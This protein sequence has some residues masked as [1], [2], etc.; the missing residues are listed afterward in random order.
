MLLTGQISWLL[1]ALFCSS[2]KSVQ[3]YPLKCTGVSKTLSTLLGIFLL[4]LLFL[5]IM[6]KEV[7]K[8]LKYQTNAT[9]QGMGEEA[10]PRRGLWITGWY[11]TI[12][13]SCWPGYPSVFAVSLFLFSVTS[14]SFLFKGNCHRTCYHQLYF[15]LDIPIKMWCD[16][17][18]IFFISSCPYKVI[19][20]NTRAALLF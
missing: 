13:P 12:N 1:W 19:A 20:N 15:L 7:L 2:I 9:Q 10:K 16:I 17:L 14:S 6:V 8:W 11:P 18:L 4:L 3:Q 5:K